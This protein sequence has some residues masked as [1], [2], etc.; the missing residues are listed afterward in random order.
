MNNPAPRFILLAIIAALAVAPRIQAV[1]IDFEP[2]RI[3]DGQTHNWGAFY[4]E[5]DF[6]ISGSANFGMYS[7][8]TT[9]IYFKGSTALVNG[10]NGQA[11]NANTRFTLTAIDGESFDLESLDLASES[12]FSSSLKPQFYIVA[13]HAAGFTSSCRISITN[14]GTGF[15][16]IP[17]GLE[18]LSSAS[19]CVDQTTHPAVSN[20]TTSAIQCDNI[21]LNAPGRKENLFYRA[22]STQQTTVISLSTDGVLVWTNTVPNALC[23][24]ETLRTLG[25]NTNPRRLTAEF[26]AAGFQGWIRM[27]PGEAETPIVL[28]VYSDGWG[29]LLERRAVAAGRPLLLW[30][31]DPEP[32]YDPPRYYA[33]AYRD[34]S[35]T[36]L[37]RFTNIWSTTLTPDDVPDLPFS[38]TGAL[39]DMQTWFAHC[40]VTNFT[41]AVTGPSG[42]LP[43]TATDAQGRYLITNAETGLYTV[44]FTYSNVAFSFQL[45]NTPGTDYQDLYFWDPLQFLAPN[46]YLYPETTTNVQVSLGFPSGGHV[47]V[48]EPEYGNLWNVV[49]TPDGIIDG[50]HPYLFYETLVP[51]PIETETGWL[52]DGNN[53]EQEFRTLLAD[54]GFVGREIDDFIDYWLPRLEGPPYYAVYLQQPEQMTT[55][56]ISPAPQSVLRALFAFRALEH[57]VAIASPRIPPF[58]R[59]GFTV[60]EWGVTGWSD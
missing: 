29:N 14:S 20:R 18:N 57:P 54:L 31:D 15:F 42:P 9:S 35:Y 12:S 60:V 11:S 1:T 45:T 59:S 34:N 44:G 21:V 52:L 4:E 53:L 17:L 38:M 24:I 3:E 10:E 39:F 49:V 50:K 58:T 28:E 19:W 40:A 23:Q 33:Y 16:T 46:I 55:F 26:P 32:Y 37:Y 30:V 56:N 2:L 25:E 41:L 7:Q 51:I 36:E 22:V 5:S 27:P 43:D 48:S 47:T 13:S 6:R 8:G